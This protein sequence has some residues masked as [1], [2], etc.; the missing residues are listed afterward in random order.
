MT[1]ASPVSRW[2]FVTTPS[3][4]FLLTASI[5]AQTLGIA[6][7]SP[8]FLKFA[9]VAAFSKAGGEAVGEAGARNET[10]LIELERR[11]DVQLE[12]VPAPSAIFE[13]GR[14]P[15]GPPA[16]LQYSQKIKIWHLAPRLLMSGIYPCTSLLPHHFKSNSNQQSLIEIE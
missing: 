5:I 7:P 13:K 9:L 8:W 1:D 6:S 12:R 15:L 3:D 11:Y 2:F 4:A 10:V 16:V 14:F